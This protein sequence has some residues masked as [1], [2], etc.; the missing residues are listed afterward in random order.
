V[1]LGKH[2]QE[3]AESEDRVHNTTQSKQARDPV[4]TGLSPASCV[5][6]SEL[7]LLSELQCP[8]LE[9]EGLSGYDHWEGHRR[10]V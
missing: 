3:E 6:W 7:L 4:L 10:L 5:T 1:T 9:H 8:S 2:L